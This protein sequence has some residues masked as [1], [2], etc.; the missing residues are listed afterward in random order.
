[1]SSSKRKIKA[2]PFIRDLRNGMSDGELMEKFALSESQLHE[3]LHKLVDAGAID[4]M[5]LFMRT[6][7]SDSTISRAFVG[8]QCA[9]EEMGLT[10]ETTA[11]PELE[12]A[13]ISVTEKMN[14]TSGVFRRML[15]KL[16]ST[17]S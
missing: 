2:K 1:M 8:A 3:L 16:G 17:G 4:E 5:E 7:L 15:A 13:D 12:T 11:L 9:M 6:S 14:T 10:K